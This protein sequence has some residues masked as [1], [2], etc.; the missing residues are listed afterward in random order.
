[1]CVCVHLAGGASSWRHPYRLTFPPVLSVRH[2]F[3][4]RYRPLLRLGTP[5]RP[6]ITFLK[7]SC[8]RG[9]PDIQRPEMITSLQLPSQHLQ[10]PMDVTAGA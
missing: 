10:R 3:L 7:P 9:L 1:M 2:C 5:V 6:G 8:N 4:G